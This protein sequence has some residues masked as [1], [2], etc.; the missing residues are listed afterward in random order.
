MSAEWD[1]YLIEESQDSGSQFP[2]SQFLIPRLL[3]Q[4]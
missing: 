1:I 4:H 3:I 2:G